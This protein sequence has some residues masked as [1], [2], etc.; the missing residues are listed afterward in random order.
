[1]EPKCAPSRSMKTEPSE[2][3]GTTMPSRPLNI[4]P[5]IESSYRR[6]VE[7]DVSKRGRPR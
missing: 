6:R 1:M 5:S 4:V 2:S 3:V 7:S